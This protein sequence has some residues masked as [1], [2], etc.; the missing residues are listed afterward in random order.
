MGRR[1]NVAR[2]RN[3]RIY[4]LRSAKGWSAERLAEALNC[5]TPQVYRLENSVRNLTQKHINRIAKVFGVAPADVMMESLPVGVHE[6]DVEPATTTHDGVDKALRGRQ[7]YLYTVLSDV[8]AQAGVQRG[9]LISVDQ[10]KNSIAEIKA[11]D[12]ALL[13]VKRGA[14]RPRLLLRQAL[15]PR[16]FVNNPRSGAVSTIVLGGSSD[17]VTVI[18]VVAISE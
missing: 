16:I 5:S 4:E 7:I 9:D 11:G 12:I 1:K 13:S 3:N 2:A 17:T 15:P 8:V 18:G 14:R 6:H 10:S